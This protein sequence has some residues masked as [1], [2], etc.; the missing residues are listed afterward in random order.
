M[1]SP[2]FILQC[3]ADT[4]YLC[5]IISAWPKLPHTVEIFQTWRLVFT[6]N[7]KKIGLAESQ[8]LAPECL[9]DNGGRHLVSTAAGRSLIWICSETK[10]APSLEKVGL[11]SIRHL[12]NFSLQR[13]D[14]PHVSWS[15]RNWH[16]HHLLCGWTE[17]FTVLTFGEQE[18][19]ILVEKWFSESFTL[20]L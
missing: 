18:V 2:W 3:F 10:S 14:L 9:K 7:L 20:W 15:Y 8:S 17:N 19:Q 13:T 4:R 16:C 1:Y 12:I 11:K 5:S 6:G